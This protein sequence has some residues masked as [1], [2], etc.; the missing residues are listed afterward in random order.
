MARA[1]VVDGTL[2][3]DGSESRSIPGSSRYA[4]PAPCPMA[5]SPGRFGWPPIHELSGSSADN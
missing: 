3:V 5:G 2:Q 4:G 1:L